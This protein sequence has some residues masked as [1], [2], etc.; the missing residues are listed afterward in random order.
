M[1]LAAL[2]G[3]V[4]ITIPPGAVP[5]SVTTLTVG[6]AVAPPA[7]S[8]LV[9]GTAMDFGPSGTQFATPLTLTLKY[10]NAVVSASDRSRLAIFAASGGSW[11]EVPES[12]T[13]EANAQ[14]SASISHFSTYAILKKAAPPS[15]PSAPSV[16]SATTSALTVSWPA[17]SGATS[18]DVYRATS[19]TGTYSLIT[20]PTGTSYTDTGL[21]ASTT[22][23]YKVAA[24]S[25]AGCSSLSAFGS[26][27]TSAPPVAVPAAPG[28]PSVGSATASTLTVSWP[29]VSGATSYDVYRAITS[30]GT[31]NV[32][33]SP[34]GTSYTDAG[35]SAST[36]YYYK[37]AAC[38]SAG[39]SSPSAF[40][41]GT[42]G[43]PPVSVPAAPSAPSVGSATTSAL[44][45][46][47]PAVSGATSYGVYRATSSMGTYSLITSP[48][49]T[50]YTDTGLSAITTYYYKIAA[51]NGAGC[52]SQSSYGSGSTIGV[53]YTIGLLSNPS[54]GGT[55]SGGGTIT[56][57]PDVGPQ[58]TTVTATPA[59]GYT[60]V[61]WT[62]NGTPV[63]TNASYQFTL[64]ASRNL[65]A[66]F[67]Q[68]GVTYSIN[69]SSN[70]SNGGTTTG[71][72]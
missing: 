12:V 69:T 11:V 7:S 40:G 6:P 34:T 57:N 46:S 58:T 3:K 55:T 29:A 62:E 42:T 41:S 61:N 5:A 18:Y 72:G 9:S 47:W 50:S 39:C 44:T 45:V 53:T 36:T 19:S 28:A 33:T 22:Y 2:A 43:A 37:V 16:G 8:A 38:S 10:E 66:N 32:I 14:V 67:S 35:L 21:S 31:Y 4:S 68:T 52:S 26:G 59:S 13:D 17:V 20:S 56:L 48:T 51:C 23:Y 60:F 25:S 63:S 27:T 70:P 54:N 49:G 64:T 65:V 30:S 15:A 1:T 71:S 24:C